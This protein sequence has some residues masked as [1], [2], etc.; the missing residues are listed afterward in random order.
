MVISINH[1]T[2]TVKQK[3]HKVT[4]LFRNPPLYNFI[5]QINELAQCVGRG[6]V[7]Q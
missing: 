7:A 2:L 3:E 1:A 5:N 6:W 4:T